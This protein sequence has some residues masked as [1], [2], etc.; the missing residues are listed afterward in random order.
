MLAAPMAEAQSRTVTVVDI[1]PSVFEALLLF[2]YTEEFT[3]GGGEEGALEALL[4]AADKYDVPR[5]QRT[6]ERALCESTSVD[7]VLERL[8]FADAHGP[9]S[10]RLRE[11]CVLL[12]AR[13]VAALGGMEE[14]FHRG[15]VAPVMARGWRSSR[16]T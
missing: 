8:A 13:N 5:L 2:M 9:C 10:A 12:A 4:A 14:G 16:R 11:H 3:P 6:C 7:N 1:E 15:G